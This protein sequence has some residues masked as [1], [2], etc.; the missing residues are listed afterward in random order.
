VRKLTAGA[1]VDW[2]E[3][4]LSGGYCDQSHLAHEFRAFSGISPGAWLSAERPFQNHM[5]MV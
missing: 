1:P 5:A 3:I 4:A 2:A